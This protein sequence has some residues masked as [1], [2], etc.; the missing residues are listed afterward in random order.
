MLLYSQLKNEETK[1]YEVI[2]QEEAKELGW[3]QNDLIFLNG[4]FYLSG[5]EP[6]DVLKLKEDIRE[7]RNHYLEIYVD[8]YQS[9]PLLWEKMDEN[10]K[11]IIIKYRQYLLDYT[12]EENWWDREPLS[13][14]EW[15]KNW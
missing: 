2:N 9:K 13:Y 5:Y 3:E 4:K 6:H 15:I 11:N 1:E 14:N 7:I 8:W 10:E 12:K